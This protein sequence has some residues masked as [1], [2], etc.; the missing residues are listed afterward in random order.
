LPV[1][2]QVKYCISYSRVIMGV[3]KDHPV[4]ATITG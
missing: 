4:T 2:Q 1:G 3:L